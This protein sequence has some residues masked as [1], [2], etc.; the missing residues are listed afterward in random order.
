MAGRKG[1]RWAQLQMGSR[2]PGTPQPLLGLPL[3]NAEA[4]PDE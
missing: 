4:D 3:D 2:T 1:L